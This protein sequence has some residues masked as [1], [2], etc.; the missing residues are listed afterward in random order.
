MFYPEGTAVLYDRLE[1]L[2]SVS[3]ESVSMSLDAYDDA[4]AV[5]DE[6]IEL[7]MRLENRTLDSFDAVVSRDGD[8]ARV[9]AYRCP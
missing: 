8:Q 3:E 6:D 4:G 7:I 5:T 1:G 9:T 2:W